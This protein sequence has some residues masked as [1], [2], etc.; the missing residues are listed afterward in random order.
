MFILNKVILDLDPKR[1]DLNSHDGDDDWAT[2]G[3]YQVS[4]E[5]SHNTE[6]ENMHLDVSEWCCCEECADIHSKDRHKYGCNESD[7]ITDVGQEM[8]CMTKTTRFMEVVENKDN[9]NYC[10]KLI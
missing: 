1:T 7:A 5:S 3:Y 4:T 6:S 2:Q 9:S 10:N 8:L